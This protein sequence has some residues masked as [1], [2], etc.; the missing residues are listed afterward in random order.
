MLT[1]TPS[2]RSSELHALT[3]SLRWLAYWPIGAF[4]APAANAIPICRSPLFNGGLLI[5][6]QNS[7]V[8]LRT[9]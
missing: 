1:L 3:G 7:G 6:Q 8:V 4:R 5:L 2:S 9:G